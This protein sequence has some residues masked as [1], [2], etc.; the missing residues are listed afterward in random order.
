VG[1]PRAQPDL[2]EEPG[3]PV[4]PMSPERAEEL[5]R[6]VGRERKTDDEP[7]YE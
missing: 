7:Q 1:L 3:G 4:D 5:L 2:L 6:A